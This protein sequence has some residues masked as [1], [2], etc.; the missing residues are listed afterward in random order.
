MLIKVS[1]DMG[2]W[3]CCWRYGK[4]TWL[5]AE[6]MA[7]AAE[8]IPNPRALALRGKSSGTYRKKIAKYT[9]TQNLEAKMNTSSSTPAIQYWQFSGFSM[10]ISN[11][12]NIA[13]SPNK[14]FPDYFLEVRSIIM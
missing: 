2:F 1:R 3:W 11:P 7:P 14:Y 9:E 5:V 6:E 10:N 4:T 12:V 8:A 13:D